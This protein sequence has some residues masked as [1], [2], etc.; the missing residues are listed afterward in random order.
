ML[1]FILRMRWDGL[2]NLPASFV[3][4]LTPWFRSEELSS[5]NSG[6]IS[7]QMG[8]VVNLSVSPRH[9]LDQ[10]RSPSQAYKI[11]SNEQSQHEQWLDSLCCCRRE[12]PNADALSEEP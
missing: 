4:L 1:Q 6:A 3:L 2:L 10:R 7:G 8:Y 9:V 12:R 11:Q 5:H